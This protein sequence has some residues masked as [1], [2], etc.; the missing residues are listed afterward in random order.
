MIENKKSRN[1]YI[2]F[3][4][5][6]AILMVILGH[7]ISGTTK[8][9]SNSLI[10]QIIWTVQMPLF[11]VI[12][13][14]VTKYSSE[15]STFKKLK[16]YCFKRTISYL[17]PWIVWTFFIRN[18]LFP[19]R[20]IPDFYQILWNMDYGYWFLISLWMISL[21]FGISEYVSYKLFK[22][23]KYLIINCIFGIFFLS[24]IGVIYG[25]N[26]LSI[27]LTV[28][29]ML[30]Y[31][32]G[33]LYSKISFFLKKILYLEEIV[34][35]SSFFIWVILIFR[36][37]FFEIEVSI[38]GIFLRIIASISGVISIFGLFKNLENKFK[39][40][41]IKWSGKHSLELYLFH[42]IFLN[43]LKLENISNFD[44]VEGKILIALNM[45]IVLLC[46]MIMIFLIQNNRILKFIFFFKK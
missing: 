20:K 10:F 28:Y 7:T 33:Y 43:Y 26:F 4:K 23:S 32:L 18:I 42:N 1:E 45:G 34:V 22:T 30:F 44:S 12:S 27:K 6:I 41:L 36:Y 8:N 9:Y 29:Y 2:D 37:N 35:T 13:G 17:L 40:S 31:L 38:L 16:N 5:G 3:I 25:F 11:F 46:S 15:I 14:F 24:I 19:I 21:I 39:F